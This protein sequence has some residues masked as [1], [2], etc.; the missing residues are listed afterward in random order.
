LP[1]KGNSINCPRALSIAQSWGSRF[2]DRI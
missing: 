2:A 1:V